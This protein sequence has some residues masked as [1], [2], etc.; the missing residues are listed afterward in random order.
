MVNIKNTSSDIVKDIADFK[1][2]SEHYYLHID[3]AIE[4]L[5]TTR[6]PIVNCVITSYSIHYTKLYENHCLKNIALYLEQ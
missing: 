1:V 2:I 3:P 5:A 4:V 6:F